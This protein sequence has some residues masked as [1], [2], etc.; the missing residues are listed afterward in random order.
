M[1]SIDIEQGS[2]GDNYFLT[3]LAALSER[4]HFI[5]KLFHQSKYTHEGIFAIKA[6]VKGRIEDVTIDDLFPTYKNDPAFARPSKD[7]GWWLPL[8]EKAYSKVHSN[9][10]SISSGTQEEAARFLTGAPSRDFS[11]NEQ[12]IDELWSTLSLNLKNDF[13]MTAA[14]NV[15]HS[16]LIQSQGY[17]VKSFHEFKS[18]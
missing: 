5:S 2:V 12:T 13:V 4:P 8:L 15:D 3:I 10:E 7:G 11:T 17:I 1:E 18:D 16:G 14:C 6:Y 9:Y